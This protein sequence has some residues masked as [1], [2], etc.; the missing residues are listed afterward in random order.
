MKPALVLLHGWG[1]HHRV[2]DALE[3][4]LGANFNVI[5]PDLH[6]QGAVPAGMEQRVDQLAAAAPAQ[7]VV[8]GWSLGGQLALVW[9]YRHPRQVQRLMLISSTPRFVSAPDWPHGMAPE[10]FDGFSASLAGDAVAT[11]RRFLLLQAQG[12]TQARKVARQ[13]ETTLALQAPPDSTVLMQTLRWLQ[14][15]DLRTTLPQITQAALVMHGDSDRVTP[16]AAGEYLAAHLPRA[17]LATL[18]GVAHAPFVSEPDVM[19][20]LMMDFCDER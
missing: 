19:C 10:V 17:R 1:A 2:W 9:A 12:D 5:A 11:L 4:R 15:T 18:S 14:T 8:A 16:L 3:I 7:C 13:L 6:G 20:R